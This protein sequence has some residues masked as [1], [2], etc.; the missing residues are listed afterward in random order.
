[1]SSPTAMVTLTK[2]GV[3][4]GSVTALREVDLHVTQGDFIA[5]IGA[6]GSGKTTLL[7]ALHGLVPHTGSRVVAER[8]GAR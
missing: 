8:A 1:M 5:L 7:Q 3:R 4:F 2:L 6:N